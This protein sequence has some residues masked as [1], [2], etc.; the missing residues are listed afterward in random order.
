MGQAT[1]TTV[2]GVSNAEHVYLGYEWNST[3]Q[4]ST[5]AKMADDSVKCWGSA[6]GNAH[7]TNL[8]SPE[9]VPGLT[10]VST[11]SVGK[12]SYGCA[13][14]NTSRVQCWGFNYYGNLGYGS[15][16]TTNTILPTP[17]VMPKAV[18]EFAVASSS[19]TRCYVY[20]DNTVECIGR[21]ES[22][23]LGNGTTIASN[24][25]VTPTGV[26]AAKHISSDGIS[27]CAI[28]VDDSIKCWGN[29]YAAYGTTPM[30]IVNQGT[31]VQISGGWGFYC[32]TLNNGQIQCWG[33]NY[34]GELGDG[35]SGS[36]TTV[37][38]LVTGINNAT[39]VSPGQNQACAI[40]GS[41]SIKCW[42]DGY[43]GALG[44]G[45]N[46]ASLTPV[47]VT[48]IANAVS[49]KSAQ[50]GHSCVVLSDSTV[51]CWGYNSSGQLGRGFVGGVYNTPA[52][53]TGLSSVVQVSV[54]YEM[55]CALMSDTTIKCWGSNIDGTF[56]TLGGGSAQSTPALRVNT[57]NTSMFANSYGIAW[58]NS[59]QTDMRMMDSL[60]PVGYILEPIFTVN[61]L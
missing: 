2:V 13:I 53:V 4:T 30:D 1:P 41:G 32:A 22:G 38:V 3:G 36:S 23:Q 47:D 14:L 8:L 7:S 35:N 20:T 40:V 54:S 48:G 49:M 61:G 44:N 26:T 33:K 46:S 34:Y 28:M 45:S 18:K 42:G 29:S 21:N 51:K 25:Y 39:F 58:F 24:T 43:L 11:L 9:V 15:R 27:F 19:G 17:V 6:R 31:P 12:Y 55:S 60:L 57:Y 10:N 52:L 16:L 37:P 5:C 56:G 50:D 59:T